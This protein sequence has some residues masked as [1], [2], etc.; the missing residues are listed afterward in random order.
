MN[1][2]IGGH[3]YQENMGYHHSEKPNWKEDV[4]KINILLLEQ[5]VD[6]TVVAKKEWLLQN[7]IT[8]FKPYDSRR[9]VTE[10]VSENEI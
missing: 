5:P 3:F 4:I 6:R 2:I 7:F 1:S 10:L 8:L 9:L